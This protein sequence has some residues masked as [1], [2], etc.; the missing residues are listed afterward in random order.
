MSRTTNVRNGISMGIINNILTIVLPFV[1]R[2]IIIRQL[3]IEYVGL[4]SLFT[5]ILQVLS[6]SELGFGTAIGYLLYKPLA[7]GDSDKVNAILYF[8]RGIYRIIGVVI[9]SLSIVILPFLD[10]LI[11]GDVP[12]GINIYILY[13]IYVINTVIS[14]FFFAYKRILLSAN[15]RYDVDVNIASVMLIA[16]YLIQI[17]TLLLFKNYY[18]YAI[19]IPMMTLLGNFVSL[20]YVNKLFPGYFCSGKLSKEEIRDIMK[21]TGGAFFSKI[22]STVYL[23]V[24]SLVISAFLGLTVLG[25][26]N[27][28]YYI[29]TSLIAIFAVIH[30]SLRPVIGNVLVTESEEKSWNIY[31]KIHNLYM[32]LVIVCCSCC[33]VLFQDF[34]RIWG[35][36]ENLLS[37][38]MVILFVLYFLFGRIFS[39]TGVFLE[40]AGILWQ[41][42][43]IPLLS[44]A[45][46]LTLNLILVQ[47][48]GLEGVMIS[49]IIGFVL[50]SYPGYTFVIFKY[51]FQRKEQ[52]KEYLKQMLDLLVIFIINVAMTWLCLNRI[53]VTGWIG[54]FFKGIVTLLVSCLLLAICNLR[55]KYLKEALKSAIRRVGKQER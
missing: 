10:N 29:I 28:Y 40:A 44:A 47:F 20:Y 2:T 51:L 14:Y 49:S 41:G 46:N 32:L 55:N 19:I 22:G 13:I 52:K 18:I 50:V 1:S 36:K 6:L 38:E 37:F 23:S 30:N 25:T 5:S 11:A 54:L 53:M 8:F 33:L 15:Q 21:T 17:I 4:G 24:D 26:Y 9:L 34:E 43:F 12:T 27:N 39:V 3:G 42:K 45:I 35:G 31:K 7:D 48:I 16:Q